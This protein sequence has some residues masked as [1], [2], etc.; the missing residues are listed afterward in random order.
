MTP[1]K[2]DLEAVLY[3]RDF[4]KVFQFCQYLFLNCQYQSWQMAKW[5]R[6]Q[7]IHLVYAVKCHL[8]VDQTTSLKQQL[9]Q[10]YDHLR[11]K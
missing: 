8:L 4:G 7:E 1:A 10:P 5:R 6:N 11:K 3:S 2:G 9:Q